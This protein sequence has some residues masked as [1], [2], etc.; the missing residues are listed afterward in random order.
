LA[1]SAAELLQ[2]QPLRHCLPVLGG[3]IVSLFAIAALQCNDLSG[4]KNQLLAF[5]SKT[6][7]RSFRTACVG[8]EPALCFAKQPP[9][10]PTTALLHNLADGSRPDRVAAFADGK[11]Q[12][13]L[14]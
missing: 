13:L 8:Q 9:P 3:R 6:K 4:H 2:F 12:A 10:Q 5:S 11:P 7:I 14:H 1:A